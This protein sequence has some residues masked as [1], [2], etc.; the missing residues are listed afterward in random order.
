M[1]IIDRHSPE[2]VGGLARTAF[3]GMALVGT[4]L[5]RRMG[6]KDTPE[7]ALQDW[8]SF[9]EFDDADVW[10]KQWAEAYVEHSADRVFH[11]LRDKGMRFM[12]A[13]MVDGIAQNVT[14]WRVQEIVDGFIDNSLAALPDW[15]A[16]RENHH[17][18]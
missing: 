7:L 2:N 15:L 3:G 12:P 13:V 18:V 8:H 1:T 17:A 14:H 11:W 6:I 16:S 10:P 4:P 5:Q 9:A